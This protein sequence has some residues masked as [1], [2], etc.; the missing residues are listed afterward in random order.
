L[1]AAPGAAISFQAD[2]PAAIEA[3]AVAI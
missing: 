3:G 2:H 1:S